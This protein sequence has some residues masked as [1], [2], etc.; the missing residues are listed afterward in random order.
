MQLTT[1]SGIAIDAENPKADQIELIDIA[2]AL[3]RVPRFVGHTRHP[4]SVAE[5]SVL[6]SYLALDKYKQPYQY[7]QGKYYALVGLFHDAAEA[8]IS[9]I[10]TP[11]KQQLKQRIVEVELKFEEAIF[12]RFGIKHPD[13]EEKAVIK[14]FDNSA[15]SIE[16]EQL[17]ADAW[18]YTPFKNDKTTGIVLPSMPADEAALMFIRQFTRINRP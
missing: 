11:I 4:Y 15:Y 16:K 1:Y 18:G 10:P 14:S 2:I 9:D 8:Y 3:S 6:V 12:D 7:N 17:R 5:H 13:P